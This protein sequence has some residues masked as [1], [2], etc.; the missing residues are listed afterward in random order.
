MLCPMANQD[1]IAKLSDEKSG[2]LGMAADE[3]AVI[4]GS[5]AHWQMASAHATCTWDRPELGTQACHCKGQ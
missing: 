1:V 5:L 2:I 3:I 4:N